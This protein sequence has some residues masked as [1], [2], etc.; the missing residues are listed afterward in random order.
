MGPA[1]STADRAEVPMAL[2]GAP[3]SLLFHW[4]YNYFI[5]W[6]IRIVV[7]LLVLQLFSHLAHQ[8]GPRDPKSTPRRLKGIPKAPP[9]SPKGLF[10]DPEGPPQDPLSTLR[11][12]P[13]IVQHAS[14]ANPNGSGPFKG[15]TSLDTRARK[16]SPAVGIFVFMQSRTDLRLT[17]P[18]CKSPWQLPT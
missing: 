5:M 3:K 1:R 14:N 12:T 6:C 13:I 15:T 2:G 8:G 16:S 18:A 4:F 17:S 7:F 10:R 9:Q 11:S